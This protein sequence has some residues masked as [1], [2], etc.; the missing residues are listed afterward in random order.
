MKKYVKYKY[1]VI[2][3]DKVEEMIFPS[4]FTVEIPDYI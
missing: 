4:D 1:E 3:E 2:E